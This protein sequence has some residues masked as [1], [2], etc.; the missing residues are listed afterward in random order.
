MTR[1][2]DDRDDQRLRGIAM[3]AFHMHEAGVT[4]DETAAAFR[5]VRARIAAGEADHPVPTV[6]PS[7]A[8]SRW[9]TAV[10]LGSVAAVAALVVAGLLALN[11]RDRNLVLDTPGP[12]S[13]STPVAT[14]PSTEPAPTSTV[15]ATTTLP[16]ATTS[17]PVAE[18]TIDGEVL[19]IP[20]SC[21]D[22]Q[23]CTQLANTEDG[24]IVAYDPTRDVLAVYD[25]TGQQLQF[26]VPLAAPIADQLPYLVSIGPADV[27]YF[28]VSPPAASDPISDLIAVPLVGPNAGIEAVRYEGLDGSG[29]STL[30]AQRAGLVS[31]GCCGP[32]ATRPT[33]DATLYP[34]VD[35][36]GT[37]IESIAPVFRLDLGEA[38]NALV[39]IEAD[40]AETAFTL[41]AVF[42]YPR[43]FPELVA[44]DDGGA[45]GADYVQLASGGHVVVVRFGTDW[46]ESGIDNVDVFLIDSAADGTPRFFPQ[47][48]ERSGTVVV[49]D[50]R[51]FVRTTLE[52][53]G[54]T[55]W[56]GAVQ[57]DSA[58][59][60]VGTAGL[61][62]YI[63]EAQPLW[64]A[65]PSLL[66]LQIVPAV[67]PNESVASEFDEATGVLTITT[68]GFLDDSVA[69]G[70]ITVVT[71]RATDGL[72]R[73]VSA[74]YGVQCQPGRGHQDF[75]T[76]LCA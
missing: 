65:D 48:L 71:E 38:G 27:A 62:D 59:G 40:G 67:G 22:S 41:P 37:P 21:T 20:A 53:I 2:H 35:G 42:Q 16:S 6:R 74:T 64:A 9:S 44:T 76:E 58:S 46:P 56:P 66:A 45:L 19:A 61:N 75:S 26:E 52:S 28:S 15:E 1:Q 24:R 12:A 72:L 39:R 7:A 51:G 33:G 4:P 11:G 60:D 14:V 30:V 68:S 25:G 32:P 43:D 23:F 31:V 36:E 47:L 17:E 18:P 73:V 57:I 5:S 49:R 55:G 3:A 63:A 8:R 69:A 54:T 34:Y 70:R 29:D 13:E 10:L 50:D